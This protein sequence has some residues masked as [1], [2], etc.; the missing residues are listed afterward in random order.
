MG[1]KPWLYPAP[2]YRSLET[3]WDTEEMLL[4]HDVVTRS[5]MLQL[6]NHTVHVSSSSVA[7][8]LSKA[9]L[10]PLHLA[11]VNTAML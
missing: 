1:S 5:Q 6:P 2:S 7:P 11:S 8:P 9:V 10:P 4:V 3:Y